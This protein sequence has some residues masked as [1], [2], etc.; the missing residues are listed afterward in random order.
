MV[1]D[2]FQHMKTQF[3]TVGNVRGWT[4]LITN[5]LL[6]DSSP[7]SHINMASSEEVGGDGESYLKSLAEEAKKGNNNFFMD[8]IKELPVIYNRACADF[9]DR[10]VKNLALT[11]A[12]TETYR[13]RSSIISFASMLL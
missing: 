13:E 10:N 12:R 3:C 5:P 4:S 6:L 1:G 9:K 7:L 11:S 2:Y 8:L